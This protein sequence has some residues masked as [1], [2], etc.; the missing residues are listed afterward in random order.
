MR[1]KKLSLIGFKS[2]AD[3]TIL[4][5]DKGI[6]CIVG[7]NGCGK[8]NISDAFRWVL[9]EQSA[10]SMRGNKMHDII[11]AG[12]SS[13]KPV[14]YAEVSL[15][16]TDLQGSLPIDYEEITITR[17]LHRSGE[18]EYLLNGNSVRLKDLQGLFLDSGV[19]RNAFSIF[20]QGKLDQIINFTP[21]ERR[22]IFEEASGILR[23][24]QRKREALKRLEDADS[25]LSRAKDIY[26]EV[27]NQIKILK[28]QSEK[29]KHYKGNKELLENLEK[30]SFVLR[31][32]SLQKRFGEYEKGQHKLQE[33]KKEADQELAQCQTGLHQVKH[34]LQQDSKNLRE[35]SENLFRIRGEKEI[36]T[37][38]YQSNL[39]RLQE[40][41]QKEKKLHQSLNEIKILQEKR[42]T[43][44]IEMQQKRT[45][46][47]KDYEEA[48]SKFQSQNEKVKLKE[49]DVAQLNN[50]LQIKRQHVVKH[51]QQE[52]QILGS[53]K[54][55]ESRLEHFIDKKNRLEE[56]KSKLLQEQELLLNSV[57]EKR[58]QFEQI[59]ALID[60]HK[61]G[62]DKYEE[63]LKGISKDIINQQ[64][65]IELLQ[66]KIFE[67][68]ARHKVLA[69]MRE[70][71]EG[72]SSGSKRLLKESENPNCLLYNKIRPVYEYIN[73]DNDSTESLST[74]LHNYSQTLVIEKKE[75]LMLVLDFTENNQ[76]KDYSI[77]CL[78]MIDSDMSL[79]NNLFP[80]SNRVINHFLR[81]VQEAK[82]HED[83]F[84]LVE[85][86]KN[87]EL[88]KHDGLF[89]DHNHVIFHVKAN[90]NQV[91]LREKELRTLTEDLQKN[92]IKL[93]ELQKNVQGLQQRRNKLQNERAELDKLLRRDEMKLVEV[94][95]GLQRTIA[96]Q[97][98]LKIENQNIEKES[99]EI[100]SQIEQQQILVKQS[101]DNHFVLKQDIVK[102]QQEVEF[103]EKELDKQTKALNLQQIDQKEKGSNA[104]KI[105]DE[106]QNLLHQLNVL[107]VQEN[108]YQKQEKHFNDEL[109]YLESMKVKIKDQS[110]KVQETLEQIDLL[111]NQN[112]D[113]CTELEKKIEEQKNKLELLEKGLLTFHDKTKNIEM[114]M[115]QLSLK[116]TQ[117]RSESQTLELELQER[118]QLE[119]MEAKKYV[120][121]N[122]S[123]DQV[124]KQIRV[125][126]QA[127]QTA[128]DINMASIEDLQKQEERHKFIDQQV[129]D[130]MGSKNEL[131]EIIKQ[132]DEESHKLFR[133]TFES[134]RI[135]FKKNFQILFNGGEADLQFTDSNDILVAGIDIIAKPPGKQMRSINLLSGGEKC[136]TAVA[137][138]FSIFE[139]KPAPFC[140]LDEIDAPLDDSNVERFTNVV[141]HF[142]DRCQFLIIT[143]NK[144][145]MAIGDI[146]F[147]VS[148][149]E[150]GVSKLLSLEFSHEAVAEP[151]AEVSVS[152]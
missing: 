84:R 118:Y 90:E 56:R 27:E 19:G 5:F 123:L 16:L 64:K 21:Q 145:T 105:A 52:S 107:E 4:N 85:K 117:N 109:A 106:R 144:R 119:I 67:K 65:D 124:E 125:L 142:A 99:L 13:R 76:I 58:V 96:D 108:E 143:H 6:T 83:F 30:T 88:W 78:E 59:S 133:E 114:E 112:N 43:T 149:E 31:W 139:V 38:E 7:P 93:D 42:K 71:N 77:L 24:L 100:G 136:L 18:S 151:E 32:D 122:K 87:C 128:G 121:P 44:L 86:E 25:N 48:Q 53:L 115:N 147:G 62:L 101:Q 23:F 126:R 57:K 36:Y 116:S 35:K 28:E 130:M 49:K 150:K 80:S 103:L 111:I 132:I 113:S 69:K 60:T 75:D 39:Q 50:E 2:F 9:G 54:Q 141:K 152:Y 29:A 89:M 82:N 120:V 135:N 97:D 1:L 74:I 127:L 55:H 68:T 73:L 10:K 45:D 70:D 129:Q 51:I 91:F 61:A 22:Y 8:S 20:E 40:S 47:E 131:L 41:D 17:R 137:L 110:P 12:A 66:K 79:K 140:I 138:L 46:I 102:V 81:R 95:F 72:F 104:R 14:N 63:E 98:K 148:M 37:R 33:Q 34:I 94:N 3:K 92:E 134:V 15:T 26:L 146:L 11:F